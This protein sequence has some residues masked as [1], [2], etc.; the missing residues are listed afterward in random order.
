MP[1]HLNPTKKQNL[2]KQPNP[3]ISP[4]PILLSQTLRLPTSPKA[5]KTLRPKSRP[6]NNVQQTATIEPNHQQPPPKPAAAG[7]VLKAPPVAQPAVA[8]PPE[9]A[10]RAA[11]GGVP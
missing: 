7:P 8:P 3:V 6:L 11:L 2:I 4:E 5:L 9:A 10:N 1:T